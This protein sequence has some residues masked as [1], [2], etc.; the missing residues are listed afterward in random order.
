MN[1]AAGNLIFGHIC[2][3]SSKLLAAYQSTAAHFCI[4]PIHLKLDKLFCFAK[5]RVHTPNCT[6]MEQTIQDISTIRSS[7]ACLQ[8]RGKARF[9]TEE[10]DRIMAPSGLRITQFNLVAPLLVG[11]CSMSDLAKAAAIDRTTLTR[12]LRPLERKGFVTLHDGKDAR[13]HIA[14]L[15][16]KGGRAATQAFSLWKVAQA[17]YATDK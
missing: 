8:A 1:C 3:V 14:A 13:T 5:I 12:N 7:C 17:Q 9:L 6:A 2:M 11:P 4:A 16:A 10:Y 15:T